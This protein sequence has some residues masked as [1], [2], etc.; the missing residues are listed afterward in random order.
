MFSGLKII[1]H[2]YTKII[3]KFNKRKLTESICNTRYENQTTSK[4][5]NVDQ[6]YNCIITIYANETE[7]TLKN[8]KVKVNHYEVK[9]LI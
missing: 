1:S 7:V 6:P 2:P 8:F 3:K 9:R 4:L 5:F